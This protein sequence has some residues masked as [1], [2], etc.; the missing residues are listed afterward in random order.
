M[1]LHNA[2]EPVDVS[3]HIPF[4]SQCNTLGLESHHAGDLPFGALIEKDGAV[5]ATGHNTGT[6]D[7]TG[8]AEINAIRAFIDAHS[9]AEL[10]TCTLYTNFEP[11]AMCSFLI[12][13]YGLRRVVFSVPSPHLGGF[14]RWSVLTDCVE[15]PFTWQGRKEGPEVIGGIIQEE[16]Q[17]IF[18]KLDWKMHHF[19]QTHNPQEDT[20]AT[21]TQ[22]ASRESS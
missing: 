19:P 11:C 21:G 18:D 7:I 17:K 2:T 15:E 16:S 9:V 14:N 5:L 4:L 13:D 10:R 3:A 20:R 12:R 1:Y 8:H 6:H 22:D